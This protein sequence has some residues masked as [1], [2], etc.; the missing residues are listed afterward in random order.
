MSL[1]LRF[2]KFVAKLCKLQ[3]GAKQICASFKSEFEVSIKC[4]RAEYDLTSDTI[5]I[6]WY[7]YA[8]PF[9]NLYIVRLWNLS[10]INLVNVVSSFIRTFNIHT[11]KNNFHLSCYFHLE[12][13]LHP[14]WLYV[15]MKQFNYSELELV[16]V[17]SLHKFYLQFILPQ[18][19]FEDKFIASNNL[20]YFPLIE[21]M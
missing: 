18:I 5:D 20:N 1:R 12:Y 19:S 15:E 2:R 16:Q 21:S 17:S 9:A 13:N 4:N 6:N 14:Y 8:H 11:Q 3:L 10:W 7:A